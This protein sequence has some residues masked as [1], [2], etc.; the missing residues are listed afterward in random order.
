M[1]KICGNFG[2]GLE[3]GSAVYQNLSSAIIAI[4]KFGVGTVVEGGEG[5]VS[6]NPSSII[7]TET[8]DLIVLLQTKNTK[9][10]KKIISLFT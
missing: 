10:E 8:F 9:Y 1:T 4:S 6:L 7:L 2:G 3:N 5:L